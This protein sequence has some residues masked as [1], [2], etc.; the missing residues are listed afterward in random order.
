MACLDS[1]KNL[2]NIS[3]NK[4]KTLVWEDEDNIR[5][6]LPALKHYGLQLLK[7]VEVGTYETEITVYGPTEKVDAFLEDVE[8][9]CVEPLES[10][11]RDNEYDE[12]YTAALNVAVAACSK[13]A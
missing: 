5:S 6:Y 1:L 7:W 13:A 11:S 9:G 2:K 8:E 4:S 12:D 10:L 3:M